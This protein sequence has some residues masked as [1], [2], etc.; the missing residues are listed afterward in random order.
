MKYK[1]PNK[2]EVT[3]TDHEEIK[4]FFGWLF[5]SSELHSNHESSKFIFA[6]EGSARAIFRCVISQL[7]F[8]TLLNY[9]RFD[10]KNS[11]PQRL[12]TNR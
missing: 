6:F 2:I 10:A 1:N 8:P 3:P 11:K 4:A 7:C 12:E 5:Y 9:I